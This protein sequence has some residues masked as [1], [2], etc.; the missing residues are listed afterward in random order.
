MADNAAINVYIGSVSEPAFYFNKDSIDEISASMGVDALGN[1]LAIDTLDLTVYHDDTDGSLRALTYATPIWY[2]QETELI[3]K[4]YSKSIERTAAQKYHITAVSVIGLLEYERHYGGF[5]S[6]KNVKDAVR[7]TFI[8]DGLKV[9]MGR[10]Y[11]QWKSASYS[12]PFADSYTGSNSTESGTQTAVMFNFSVDQINTSYASPIWA[13]ESEV[14][15]ENNL[16]YQIGAMVRKGS[17]S[18]TVQVFCSLGAST[19]LTPVGTFTA[20]YG[21]YIEL[22]ILPYLGRF[23]YRINGGTAL[24]VSFTAISSIY[25]VPLFGSA[26]ALSFENTIDPVKVEV[27]YR[28]YNLWL[29]SREGNWN[30]VYLSIIPAENI[31]TGEQMFY[32]RISGKSFQMDGSTTISGETYAWHYEVGG[33]NLEVD[34]PGFLSE[35][36]LSGELP[37]IAE[38]ITWQ[39]GS[40]ALTLNG[41]IRP[42]TKREVL[43]Q[44]LFALNLNMLKSTDGNIIIGTLPAAV[45]GEIEEDD[46]YNEGS[47]EEVK[48]PK[49]IELTEHTFSIPTGADEEVFDNSAATVGSEIYVAEFSSAPIYGRPTSDSLTILAYNANAALVRGKGS[50]TA[51]VYKHFT[52][53]ITE[54]VASRPDGETISVSDATLV[55][56]LNATNV[57][58]KLKAYYANAVYKI[59]NAII[60]GDRKLGRKYSLLSPFKEAAEAYLLDVT[61][62]ASNVLKFNCEFI[63]DYTPADSGN[64]YN[65]VELLTGSGTWTVPENVTQIHI[66]LIGG[67]TGGD[68]GFAGEDGQ[69]NSGWSSTT[70]AEGGA[71]GENGSGGKVYAIDVPVTPGQTFSF[72]CGSGGP[73][74]A[75]SNSHD[76]NNPGTSGGNTTF[77]S[78]SSA[79]GVADDNGYT[80][81]LSGIIYAAK[82]GITLPD[83]GVG[84]ALT[85]ARYSGDRPSER[86]VSK[87]DATGAYNPITDLNY[88]GGTSRASYS[89][90]DIVVGIGGCGGGGALGQAGANYSGRNGGDGGDATYIPP[91]SDVY[92]SRFYG[93]GGF[94]G[95]GGGGGGSA[96]YVPDEESTPGAGG[97]GGQGG[98]GGDGCIFVY[99]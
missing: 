66:V 93:Y 70:P 63:A 91:K 34:A 89:I 22:L 95:A 84:G 20:T 76:T 23:I 17:S 35:A 99:S 26:G 71:H 31:S 81:I 59:K 36:D 60:A 38:N 83:G 50:I 28:L 12:I 21:D 25:Q 74:G 54:N 80:E 56:F 86:D 2:Y 85:V 9:L 96:G 33:D 98:Q 47:V 24:R 68:S 65:N 6:A 55:T 44:I 92:N 8:T 18:F 88:R 15:D 11:A 10:E 41:W 39:N 94:G 82:I 72:S 4:F 73:G 19:Q 78:Y 45:S 3:G 61:M 29:G 67:G 97:Y 58:N 40:D 42:G 52:R 75:I 46:I 32:D 27:S 30:Q 43:H 57:M 87:I 37:T 69:E 62:N 5:Y 7:E 53:V 79:S 77:G 49:K 48:K 16:W 13:A 51:K 14:D 90:N 64:I 1:E